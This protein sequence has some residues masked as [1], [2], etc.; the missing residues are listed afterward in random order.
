MSADISRG[1]TPNPDPTL[2]TTQALLREILALRELME[3]KIDNIDTRLDERMAGLKAIQGEKFAKVEQQFELV[4]RQRVEQKQ[5]T[6][7]AV[8]AAL[9]AQKEAVH[10]QT[11]A[12]D[13][14]ISKSEQG[15]TKQIDQLAT[16]FDT[17]I[18]GQETQVDDLKERMT[19][20]ETA[21]AAKTEQ[22]AETRNRSGEIA[23]WAGVIFF[24]LGFF[25]ALAVAIL[26]P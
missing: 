13:K 20:V 9:S 12:S 6:K 3:T 24:G 5:D 22:R 14:A 8:D 23:A 19:R 26:K 18:K 2:L 16:N 15:T 10:E 7:T 1:S 21:Q 4:E 11:L 17:A 25:V